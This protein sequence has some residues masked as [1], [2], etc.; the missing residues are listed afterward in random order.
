MLLCSCC[1]V[2]LS[3][4]G[5]IDFKIGFPALKPTHNLVLLHLMDLKQSGSLLVP[6]AYAF[7]N[8][9]SLN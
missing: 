2:F 4:I 7:L 5:N 8:V 1:T 3:A 6:N 9:F